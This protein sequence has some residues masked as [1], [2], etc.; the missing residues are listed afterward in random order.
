MRGLRILITGFLIVPSLVWARES[1]AIPLSSS[2]NWSAIF[3]V[4]VKQGSATFGANGLQLRIIEDGCTLV[5]VLETNSMIQRVVAAGTMRG[6]MKSPVPLEKQGR[7][8]DFYLRI[9]IVE[10]GKRRLSW[11]EKLLA[12]EWIV[13][14]EQLVPP[15]VGIGSIK[16][17]SLGA[18]PKL[19]GRQWKA[20]Y[21]I[22]ECQLRAL[23][24]GEQFELTFD[25]AKPQNVL[26]IWLF[27][28]GDESGSKFDVR[29]T[30]L[31]LIPAK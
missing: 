14:M 1:V 30:R 29:L 15:D 6:V 16:F 27:A 2:T 9:G 5:H 3:A 4:P 25:L 8:K 13:R 23:K 12:S 31:E 19:D 26:A 21:G 17:F 7:P 18:D 22:V 24:D 28:D 20:K 10:K 11:L